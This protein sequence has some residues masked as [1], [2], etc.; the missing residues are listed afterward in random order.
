MNGGIIGE[1]SYR[2]NIKSSNQRGDTQ[3]LFG[4][5]DATGKKNQYYSETLNP[6]GQ[7]PV[8]MSQLGGGKKATTYYDDDNVEMTSG[9]KFGFLP[10]GSYEEKS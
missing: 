9:K 1:N 5:S 6:Y 8:T 4:S 10:W 3:H 2:E 7:G